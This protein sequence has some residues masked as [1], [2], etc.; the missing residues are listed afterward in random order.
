MCFSQTAVAM[1]T[2]ISLLVLST[3]TQLVAPDVPSPTFSAVVELMSGHSK[4][5]SGENIRLRCS[6]PDGNRSRWSYLWFRGSEQLPQSGE[7]LVLWKARVQESGKYYCQGL[8]DTA[9]GDIRTQLSLPVEITVD[10]GWAI[11]QIPRHPILVGDT[12]NITCRVRANPQLEEVFLYKDDVEVMRQRGPNPHFSLSIL[13]LKDQGMYSCRASWDID[14]LTR[15]VSSSKTS[16]KV[17]EVLSQPILEIVPNVI[18]SEKI[19]LIC[20]VQYNAP[21]PAPPINYFFYKNDNRLGP[22]TSENYDLVRKAPGEYSCKAKVPQTGISRWSEPK[23][24][25]Q[26]RV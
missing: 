5:F 19:K 21:A 13:T 9:V 6:V 22:A 26:E 7:H 16:V 12:L 20:H 8:R 11:L 1:D 24:F 15:S 4:I 2:V 25:G 10:G 17:L 23:R 14:R 18:S 3:L